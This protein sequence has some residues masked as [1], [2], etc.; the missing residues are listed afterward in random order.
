[1][2]TSLFRLKRKRSKIKNTRNLWAAHVR[3]RGRK[4]PDPETSGIKLIR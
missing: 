2:P 3:R 1:L 4:E